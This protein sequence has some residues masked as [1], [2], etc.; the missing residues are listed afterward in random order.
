LRELKTENAYDFEVVSGKETV[1]LEVLLSADGNGNNCMPSPPEKNSPTSTPNIKT[2]RAQ[3]CLTI[4]VNVFIKYK[5][6]T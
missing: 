3:F 6:I 1:I 4:E 2:Q 5:I